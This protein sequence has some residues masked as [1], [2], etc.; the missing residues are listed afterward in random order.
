MTLKAVALF[1]LAEMLLSLTPGPLVLLVVG[2]SL[3]GGFRI[4]FGASPGIIAV[5]A[6]YFTLS[7]LGAG[8]AIIA[9]AALFKAIKWIGAVYLASPAYLGLRMIRPLAGRRRVRTSPG[10]CLKPDVGRHAA[11]RIAHLV[12]A[13]AGPFGSSLKSTTKSGLTVMPP[14]S[15]SQS[16]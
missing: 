16:T 5:N 14:L 13:R 7:A 8:A 6:V 15:V 9:S 4:G 12:T 3:R 11:A 2:L 10:S 1:A